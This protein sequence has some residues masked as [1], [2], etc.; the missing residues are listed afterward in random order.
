MASNKTVPFVTNPT[1]VTAERGRY[2]Q[3]GRARIRLPLVGLA[4]SAGLRDYPGSGG[5]CTEQDLGS[6]P[7]KSRPGSRATP[8]MAAF[9]LFRPKARIR[10]RRGVFYGTRANSSGR[11]EQPVRTSVPGSGTPSPA[12]QDAKR[13]VP[14]FAGHRPWEANRTG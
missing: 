13:P 1:T 3:V 4:K 5:R 10:N 9:Y 14:A 11:Q 2:E 12:H 6:E 8:A 7:G